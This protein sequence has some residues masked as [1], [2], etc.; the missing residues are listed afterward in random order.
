[1]FLNVDMAIARDMDTN[2]GLD[3]SDGKTECVVEVENNQ[4]IETPSAT[5]CDKAETN[6]GS[7]AN[8]NIFLKYVNDN[9][10]FVTKFS[11]V[12]VKMTEIRE[13]ETLQAATTSSDEFR[14][15]DE[16][17]DIEEEMLHDYINN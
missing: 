12:F 10:A 5:C 15:D 1:M 14:K 13:D 17:K 7:I 9:A 16:D 3:T 11:E 2:G 4:C 8:G 6:T